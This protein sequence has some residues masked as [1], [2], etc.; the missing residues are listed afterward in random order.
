[1]QHFLS[2]QYLIPSRICHENRPFFGG[3]V[4]F[5]PPQL[6]QPDE[7]RRIIGSFC[8]S[9]HVPVRDI[10]PNSCSCDLHFL[11]RMPKKG[12]NRA[13]VNNPNGH[14]VVAKSTSFSLFSLASWF[15][16]LLEQEPNSEVPSIS[17]Y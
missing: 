10:E 8:F 5:T 2:N 17:L 13:I 11:H 1:M 7:R 9:V 6:P 4:R 14:M 15:A 12:V 16:F 3:L